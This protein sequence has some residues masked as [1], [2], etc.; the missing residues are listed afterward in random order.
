MNRIEKK[1]I[2]GNRKM[3]NT[4]DKYRKDIIPESRKQWIYEEERA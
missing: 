1:E 2:Y 4:K 3:E